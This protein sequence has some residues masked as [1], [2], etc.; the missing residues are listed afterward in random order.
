MDLWWPNG[1]GEAKL[2]EVKIDVCDDSKCE[3]SRL[4]RVGFRT[5]ELIQENVNDSHGF[6]LIIFN[7]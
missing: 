6:Q 3:D 1:M 4:F 2:Y 5:V 7:F